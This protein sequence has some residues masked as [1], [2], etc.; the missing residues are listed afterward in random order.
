MILKW[1]A[2]Q[3]NYTPCYWHYDKYNNLIEIIPQRIGF[4]K[5]EIT[6][7]KFI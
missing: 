5:V 1:S 7:S 3:P 2:E 6:N 4:R